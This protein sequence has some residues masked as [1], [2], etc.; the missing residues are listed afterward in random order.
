ML[1]GL[2]P[3]FVA[4]ALMQEALAMRTHGGRAYLAAPVVLVAVALGVALLTR[5]HRAAWIVAAAGVP[6][7]VYLTAYPYQLFDPRH[8]GLVVVAAFAFAGLTLAGPL[9]AL[10]SPVPAVR[11]GVAAGFAAGLAVGPATPYA[12]FSFLRDGAVGLGLAPVL[13]VLVLLATGVALFWSW[14]STV[15][16]PRAWPMTVLAVAIGAMLAV[17]QYGLYQTHILPGGDDGPY[18]TGPHAVAIWAW[19]LGLGA[20]VSV[21]LAVPAYRVAG[22]AGAG[23]AVAMAALA[24]PAVSVFGPYVLDGSASRSARAVAAVVGVGLGALLASRVDSWLPWAGLGLLAL[25]I[26]VLTASSAPWPLG[27]GLAGLVASAALTSLVRHTGL[28][29]G[30]VG[31]GVAAWLYNGRALG[32]IVA[33]DPPR[34]VVVAWLLA[35]A[36]TLLALHLIPP[37]TRKGLPRQTRHEPPSLPWRATT[38]AGRT[39]P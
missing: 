27:L 37:F 28:G 1:T 36:L 3:A 22:P 14:P 5:L 4:G 33:V 29:A 30:A 38:P 13:G 26:W 9:L 10:H 16:P 12:P 6:P 32:P 21:A 39:S 2:L 7:V 31:L 11:L 8:P 24:Y 19:S 17:V 18:Q 35:G 34:P 20:L 15:D 25:A 23:W